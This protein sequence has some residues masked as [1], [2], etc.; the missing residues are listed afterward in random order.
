MLLL[1]FMKTY[2]YIQYVIIC[3][4]YPQHLV[5]SMIIAIASKRIKNQVKTYVSKKSRIKKII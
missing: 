5:N 1:G 2:C 4:S 3:M